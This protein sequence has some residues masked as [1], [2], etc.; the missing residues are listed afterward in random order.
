M[1]VNSCFIVYQYLR[2]K[3]SHF[4]EI[5][6]GDLSPRNTLMNNLYHLFIKMY[7]DKGIFREKE[8]CI[9]LQNKRTV[10]SKVY[11]TFSAYSMYLAYF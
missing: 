8:I 7:I 3:T 4:R 2:E 11:I 9:L 1:S 5:L 6:K 10:S